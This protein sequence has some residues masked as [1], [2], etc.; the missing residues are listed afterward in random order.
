[1]QEPTEEI[2]WVVTILLAIAAIVANTVAGTNLGII[3]M[4]TLLA[5]CGVLTMRYEGRGGPY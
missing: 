1:M 5:I 2:R 3:L 4:I